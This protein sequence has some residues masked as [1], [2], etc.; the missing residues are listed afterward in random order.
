[1]SVDDLAQLVSNIGNV[2]GARELEA[3]QEVRGRVCALAVL[4]QN[5]QYDRF[6]DSLR[7]HLEIL[8]LVPILIS[9]TSIVTSVRHL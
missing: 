1:M 9:T 3:L 8:G 2:S 5:S 6:D 7:P 4:F